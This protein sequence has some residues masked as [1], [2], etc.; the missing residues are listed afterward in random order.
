MS[1]L[2]W[3][4]TGEK[5]FR[6]GVEKVTFYGQT[7]A[8]YGNGEAW[9]GVTT[10]NETP[11]GGEPTKIYADDSHYLTM[12]SLETLNG[13]IEAYDYPDGFKACNGEAELTAGVTV[14]QQTRK[15][16]GLSFISLIGNDTESIDYGKELHILYNCKASPSETGHATV[17]ESPEATTMSWSFTTDP[18]EMPEGYKPSSR[19][20]IESTKVSKAAW[21]ALVDYCIGTDGADGESGTDPK[22]PDPTKVLELA[23][24]KDEDGDEEHKDDEDPNAE[25]AG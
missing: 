22:L 1:R 24:L 19:I 2:V 9:N 16:F 6:T 18:I 5:K 3:H 15:G 25:P 4:K 14:S 8:G 11:E 10:L 12:Y 17:N 7:A 20:V 23:A 13:T 21:K